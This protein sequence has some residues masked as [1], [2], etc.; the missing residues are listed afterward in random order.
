MV[1]IGTRERVVQILG[2]VVLLVG[3]FLTI[4]PFFY[5]VSAS[6]KPGS[7]LYSIPVKVLP[8]DLYLGQLSAALR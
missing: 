7:E 4:M 5:M 3:V 8:R 6:F 2:N 1:G